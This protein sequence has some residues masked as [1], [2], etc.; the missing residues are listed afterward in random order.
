METK[1]AAVLGGLTPDPALMTFY[2][3]A[4]D[5]QTETAARTPN[6]S[7]SHFFDPSSFGGFGFAR[8]KR[9]TYELARGLGKAGAAIAHFDLKP[10]HNRLCEG[11]LLRSFKRSFDYD[12]H[13]AFFGRMAAGVFE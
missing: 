2:D 10:I 1:C 7:S 12:P 8:P 9:L 13:R 11:I 3:R 5:S 4:A 6:G